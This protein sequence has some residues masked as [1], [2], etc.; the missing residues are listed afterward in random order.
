MN[1]TI[2]IKMEFLPLNK[3]KIQACTYSENLKA[4][5]LLRLLGIN[6]KTTT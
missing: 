3:D 5:G 1:G 4:L 2:L 6:K